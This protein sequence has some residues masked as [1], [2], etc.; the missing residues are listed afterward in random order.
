[1]NEP[2]GWHSGPW[3][4][5]VSDA[6]VKTA[7]RPGSDHRSDSL[8]KRT[9]RKD[10]KAPLREWKKREVPPGA[11]TAELEGWTAFAWKHNALRHSFISYCVAQSPR[12][13]ESFARSGQF[14]SDGVLELP[15]AGPECRC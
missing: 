3:G 4:A 7:Q 13:G 1:M 14:A 10:A 6:R 2:V 9:R 11:E 15:R 12:R 8:T 5:W